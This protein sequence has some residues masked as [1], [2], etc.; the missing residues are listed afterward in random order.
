MNLSNES[1]W[2]RFWLLE[3]KK[4]ADIISLRVSTY[5]IDNRNSILNTLYR[6]GSTGWAGYRVKLTLN[7]SFNQNFRRLF[8]TR[9]SVSVPTTASQWIVY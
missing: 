3:P 4:F 6:S 7:P 1:V 8:E 5:L 9:L 2:V